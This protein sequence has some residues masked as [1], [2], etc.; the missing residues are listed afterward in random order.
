MKIK[1][2]PWPP[3]NPHQKFLLQGEKKLSNF[4]AECRYTNFFSTSDPPKGR[5]TAALRQPGHEH[6][7][8]LQLVLMRHPPSYLS[9]LWGRGLGGGS[10]QGSGGVLPGVGGGVFLPGVGGGLAGGQGASSQG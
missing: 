6:G 4:E 10:S 9:K 8:R 3:P 1:A 5:G 2:T 7:G